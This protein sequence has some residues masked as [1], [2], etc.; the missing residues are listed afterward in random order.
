M[1][2]FEDH[3]LEGTLTCGNPLQGSGGVPPHPAA[4]GSWQG[5]ETFGSLVFGLESDE[6][7]E[8]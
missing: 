2:T 8:G 5:S 1:S 3:C 6:E 4:A 7:E